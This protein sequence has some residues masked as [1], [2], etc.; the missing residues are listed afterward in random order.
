MTDRERDRFDALLE[1]VLDGLPARVRTLIDQVPLVVLDRPTPKM[2]RQL[3][4]DG[5]LEPDADPTELCG[6]HSGTAIT[7]RSIDDPH[8]WGSTL[9]GPDGFAPEQIHIFRE[10]IVALATEDQGWDAQ[11]ADENIYEEIRVTVLHEVGHHFG[12]DEEDLENLGY[13]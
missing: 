12:L 7:D 3:Q 1:D 9:G 6:L 5:V 4:E 11:H 2:I 10:G 8:G 13:A